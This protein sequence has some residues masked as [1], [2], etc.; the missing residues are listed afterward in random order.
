M[1]GCRTASRRL[2][3]GLRKDGPKIGIRGVEGRR[4]EDRTKD[5]GGWFGH[6]LLFGLVLGL[7]VLIELTHPNHPL[8][9]VLSF[10]EL[11]ESC[12]DQFV[13]GVGPI[14]GTAEL[15]VLGLFVAA[16][17]GHGL[18]VPLVHHLNLS[19]LLVPYDH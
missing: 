4:G 17:E 14:D 18:L 5:L 12:I 9:L 19:V 7:L 2:G 13:I 8:H 1:M 11:S 3:Y 6:W 10:L 16:V 15:F